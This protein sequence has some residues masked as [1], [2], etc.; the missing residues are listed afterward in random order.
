MMKCDSKSLFTPVVE[1]F[2]LARRWGFPRPDEDF[3][4]GE[5]FRTRR[6]DGFRQDVNVPALLRQA[7]GLQPQ[8][9]AVIAFPANQQCVFTGFL[10]GLRQAC[11]RE[12]NQNSV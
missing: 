1:L 12:F 10:A 3:L 8:V 6:I 5:Q 9:G 7:R 4:P 11:N 2:L